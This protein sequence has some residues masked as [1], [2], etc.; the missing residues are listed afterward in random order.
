[1][2]SCAYG[3]YSC[4]AV[5]SASTDGGQAAAPAEEE[6]DD[7]W[8]ANTTITHV[9]Y[10]VYGVTHLWYFIVGVLLYTW[11]PNLIRTD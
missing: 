1:M 4:E 2:T 7:S 5:D 9:V 11:Y 6:I 8:Y 10:W 3:D